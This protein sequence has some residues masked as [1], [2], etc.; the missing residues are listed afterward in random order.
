MEMT[1][2]QL[3]IGQAGI[4]TTEDQSDLRA[5]PGLFHHFQAGFTRIQQ[6]PGNASITSTGTKYQSATGQGL[7]KGGDHLGALQD[8]GGTGSPRIGL[9]GRKHPG[10]H[11]HQPRQAHVLHGTRSPADIAG[12][13]GIDQD[14]TNVLQQGRRSRT[15]N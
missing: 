12:V 6:R 2:L 13:A 3:V 7:L 14:D 1:S 15:L 10:L 8:I 11:Q 9:M 4:F 5:L